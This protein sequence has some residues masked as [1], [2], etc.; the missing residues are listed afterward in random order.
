MFTKMRRT[1][2]NEEKA[3]EYIEKY[4]LPEITKG[5]ERQIAYAEKLRK[6]WIMEP[7]VRSDVEKYIAAQ[8]RLNDK[9]VDPAVRAAF[10]ESLQNLADTECGGDITKA[11]EY[12]YK[13]NHVLTVH[14]VYTAANA[15]E[16]IDELKG[17]G[18]RW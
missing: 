15:G 11:F 7:D 10:E 18:Y 9:T 4:N 16:I 6:L 17:Y 14:K 3:V 8:E 1:Q 12:L 13:Q 2:C 5:T